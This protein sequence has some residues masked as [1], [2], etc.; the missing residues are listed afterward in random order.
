MYSE[1]LLQNDEV[2]SDF[3]CPL[4]SRHIWLVSFAAYCGHFI[5]IVLY[6]LYWSVTTLYDLWKAWQKVKQG[7]A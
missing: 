1:A 3:W 7:G 5:P 6:G 4:Y 2:V